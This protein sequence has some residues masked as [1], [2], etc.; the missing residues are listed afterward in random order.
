LLGNI[1]HFPFTSS[2]PCP[3]IFLNTLFSNICGLCSVTVRDCD[4]QPYRTK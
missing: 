1:L 2:F 4:I 3:D